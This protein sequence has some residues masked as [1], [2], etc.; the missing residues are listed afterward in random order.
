MIKGFLRFLRYFDLKI[1][2]IDMKTKRKITKLIIHCAATPPNLDVGVREIREW[3]LARNMNDIGYHHVI[4]RDGEC[5]EGRHID[6]I[7]AHVKGQ[8][9]GSIGVCL[10]GGVDEYNNPD[11]NFTLA[12]WRTLE[13][14]AK[15]FKASFPYATIHG[16]NEFAN[17]ACPSF[18]V[19]NWLK[20]VNL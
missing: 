2:E 1:L 7:G 19:Q 6:L 3:H 11:D 5:E 20:S 9:T 8:N 4:R 12:Q 16:H 13:N 14:Y 18:D 10:V 15:I 17:K